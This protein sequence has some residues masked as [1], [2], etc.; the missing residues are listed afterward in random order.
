MFTLLHEYQY[1]IFAP[2]NL[3]DIGSFGIVISRQSLVRLAR[4]R[5]DSEQG[6]KARCQHRVM[7]K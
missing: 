7:K 4:G 1:P 5:H 6:R 3:K 2:G